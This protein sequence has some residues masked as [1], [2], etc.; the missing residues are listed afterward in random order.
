MDQLVETLFK[1]LK[2]A[3]NAID[4]YLS[5]PVMRRTESLCSRAM[6]MMVKFDFL[7]IYFHIIPEL[8]LLMRTLK[9]SSSRIN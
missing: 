8:I 7:T 5:P 1:R 4:L 3:E 9:S 6:G 2:D